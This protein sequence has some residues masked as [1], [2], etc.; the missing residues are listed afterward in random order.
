[1]FKVPTLAPNVRQV[2]LYDTDFELQA[3]GYPSRLGESIAPTIMYRYFGTI[4]AQG[5]IN[6]LF[7]IS[8]YGL[9]YMESFSHELYDYLTRL[10]G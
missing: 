6:R 9:N 8:S 2:L 5:L 10:A 3:H 7:G 4:R 1:M